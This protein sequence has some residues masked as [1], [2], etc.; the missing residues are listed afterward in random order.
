MPSAT[1]Q[2]GFPMSSVLHLAIDETT[3]PRDDLA[4]TARLVRSAAAGDSRSWDELVARF[5][6]RMRAAARGFRLSKADVD[7]VVQAAWLAAFQH[8]NRLEKPE[9]IGSWLLVTVRRAA[10]RSLQRNARELLL[11]ELPTPTEPDAA[12]PAAVVIEAER[13]TAVLAAVKRLPDRHQP[14]VDPAVAE[15]QT[16]Y[17]ELSVKLGMP[18]GS[19]GPT[20]GRVLERMR[21][22]PRLLAAVAA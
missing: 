15:A 19:I 2:K 20:R 9:S 12:G 3:E 10:L 21:R 18:V 6:P 17:A 13:R 14:L 5:T 22:D 4:A 7:D 1:S 16:S 11:E 8:I